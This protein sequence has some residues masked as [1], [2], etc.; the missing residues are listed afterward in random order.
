[1]IH[2]QA[3]VKINIIC[4]H[5]NYTAAILKVMLGIYF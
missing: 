3:Y 5:L 2:V 1:M 4:N